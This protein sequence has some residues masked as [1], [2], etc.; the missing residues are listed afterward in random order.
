MSVWRVRKRFAR[1]SE[2][3]DIYADPLLATWCIDCMNDEV[4]KHLLNEIHQRGVVEP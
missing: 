3:G 4:A 2:C 1:I